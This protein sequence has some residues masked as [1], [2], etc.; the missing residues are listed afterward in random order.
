[1]SKHRS[2]ALRKFYALI[3]PALFQGYFDRLQ[4]RVRPGAW[5]PLNLPMFQEFLDEPANAEAAGLIMPIEN[6]ELAPGTR[7]VARHKGKE[8][9]CEVVKTGDGLR[10]RLGNG[11]EFNSPSSAGREIT[12]GVAV[13]GWRFWSLDGDLKPR[14]DKKAPKAAKK[15]PAKGRK[16][17]TTSAKGKAQRAASRAETYGCGACGETFP[18][19]KAAT[20]HAKDHL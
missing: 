12:G 20:E 14:R 15:A 5:A 10:Y 8:H 1:V 17:A 7:L 2:F 4:T 13:N 16:A 9:T 6:R 19:M 11:K 18:T 3:P